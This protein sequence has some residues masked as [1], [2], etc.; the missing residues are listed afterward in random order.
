MANC[1]RYAAATDLADQL[2]ARRAEDGGGRFGGGVP[3]RPSG[4]GQFFGHGMRYPG[5]PARSSAV[6]SSK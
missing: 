1:E 2:V 6:D 5:T 3:D 4:V